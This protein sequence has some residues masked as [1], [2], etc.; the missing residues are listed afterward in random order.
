[1]K[2]SAQ[3]TLNIGPLN[4]RQTMLVSQVIASAG[5]VTEIIN[6]L[7]DLTRARLGSG[8]QIIKKPMDMAFVSRQLVDEMRA[9]HP[10]RTFQLEISGETEGNWDKARI[11]QVFSNLL[12]NAVQ[13]GFKDL[14]IGVTIK[15][16]SEAVLVSVHNDGVPIHPEA[17]GR[18]FDALTRGGGEKSPNDRE[19]MNLG[20]GLYIRRQIVLAHG[21][22]IG[23]TSSEK[24][25][26]CFTATFPR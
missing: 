20:L 4:E 10:S 17:M 11:G 7:L 21:G 8:L 15:G 14:P 6:H 18:I 3:L 9:M 16:D 24:A 25:G 19:S 12:G 13:Y 23:A 5:R 22:R 1:M 2:M 26:T